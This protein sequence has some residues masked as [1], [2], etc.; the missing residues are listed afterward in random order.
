MSCRSALILHGGAWDIPDA[1][2]P[3]HL[4]G[5]AQALEVGRR[6]LLEGRSALEVVVAVIRV[7]EEHPA[8]DAGV[9]AVLNRAGQIQLDAGLMDGHTLEFGAVA[10]VQRIR[11]PIEA[12]YHILRHGRGQ[13]S[14]L[15][16]PY[17]EAYAEAHGLEMVLPEFFLTERERERFLRLEA[18][19]HYHSSRAF[20]GGGLPMGTV[21]C[22]AL[23]Q[24]GRIAA[25]T[26]TGGAPYVIP[27]RVGDSPLPGCGYYATSHGGASAT[28]WGEAIA[29]LLLSAEAVRALEE[30]LPAQDAAERALRRLVERV[31]DPDGYPAAAGLIVLDAQGRFGVAHSAPRMAYARWSSDGDFCMTVAES[32]LDGGMRA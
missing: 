21:G 9:G 1:E 18:E 29:R 32:K 17:A 11:Y 3:D 2:V 23:D 20:R 28:G 27:G 4:T 31:R 22:V 19:V 24:A 13:Y 30:G 16:G 6:A 5:M 26:S 25:G 7:L 15:V 10:C 8:F 14:L 12:A